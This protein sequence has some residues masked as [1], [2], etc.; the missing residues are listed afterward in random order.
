M[1]KGSTMYYGVVGRTTL[2]CLWTMMGNTTPSFALAYALPPQ[3]VPRL[4][5]LDRDG[6]LNE[7]VGAPGVLSP[8]ALR[9]VPR[10]AAAVSALRR[11]HRP[12]HVVVVTNQSCVGKG[13]LTT[14][15]LQEI[16][17]ALLDLLGGGA[18]N[19]SVDRIYTC[20]ST[21]ADD[22]PRRKPR[23]GMIL[24]ARRDFGLL[25]DDDD[26]EV[27]LI[28]DSLTDLQAAGGVRW[29]ILVSTGHGARVVG[30]YFPHVEEERIRASRRARN[31]RPGSP[32]PLF[33]R[34]VEADDLSDADDKSV[35]GADIFPFWYTHNLSSAVDWLV[36]N[37]VSSP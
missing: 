21:A 32:P 5:L 26:D 14:S 37:G 12:S 22:D 19:N 28:G 3:R 33:V 10:A 35:V 36:S 18:D 2:A 11:Q 15:A 24:E 7:D 31:R 30:R 8:D 13:L 17:A 25:D 9:L 16:H 23:P 34:K 20:T 29:R 27:C 1:G 6:V 4:V